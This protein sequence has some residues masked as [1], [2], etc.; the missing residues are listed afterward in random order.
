MPSGT[1]CWRFDHVG[2]TALPGLH[3]K[4]RARH[5]SDRPGCLQATGSAT[6]SAAAGHSTRTRECRVSPPANTPTEPSK[7]SWSRLT[8]PT[9][10]P[11]KPLPPRPVA[12]TACTRCRRAD[13]TGRQIGNPQCANRTIYRSGSHS[14]CLRTA[15]APRVVAGVPQGTGYPRHR[16]LRSPNRGTFGTTERRRDDCHDRY[17]RRS[18]ALSMSIARRLANR[19][20]SGKRP[21]ARARRGGWT[22]TQPGQPS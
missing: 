19:R 5:R 13:P 2:S 16:Q 8:P 11:P 1:R 7:V 14:R 12:A 6:Q 21:P 10:R 3:P 15:I 17:V 4:P 22:R 20:R 9:N 18:S